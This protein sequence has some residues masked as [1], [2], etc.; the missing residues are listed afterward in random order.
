MITKVH[1]PPFVLLTKQHT[2]VPHT[3]TNTLA[4]CSHYTGL[5]RLVYAK[6]VT[7]T[8]NKTRPDDLPFCPNYIAL[9][10]WHLALINTMDAFFKAVGMITPCS[11]ALS[12]SRESLIWKM[13]SVVLLIVLRVNV[14]FNLRLSAWLWFW[15]FYR[16]PA[17]TWPILFTPP[18][19]Q[20]R[21][22]ESENEIN[23]TSI[24]FKGTEYTAHIQFKRHRSIQSKT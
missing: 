21:T 24:S 9:C 13:I 18:C 20:A 11:H 3:L 19:W 7:T 5:D 22:A 12:D 6:S 23:G 8:L 15:Y 14:C 2:P 10:M 17:V 16:A 1:L 4:E